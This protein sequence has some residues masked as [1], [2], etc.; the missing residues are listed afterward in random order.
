MCGLDAIALG[1]AYGSTSLC[2]YEVSCVLRAQ[3]CVF[4]KPVRPSESSHVPWTEAHGLGVIGIPSSSLLG[5]VHG[6]LRIWRGLCVCAS[7]HVPQRGGR[8]GVTQDSAGVGLESSSPK[9]A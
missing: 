8:E 2:P 3:L 1:V 5:R 9:N 7:L 4:H 6:E